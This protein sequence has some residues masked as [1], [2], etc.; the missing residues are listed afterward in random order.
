VG[1]KKKKKNAPAAEP[2]ES[3]TSTN[4]LGVVVAVLLLAGLTAA[5]IF[6]GRQPEA[7]PAA[8]AE[9][10]SEVEQWEQTPPREIAIASSDAA[11]GP[12]DAPVTLV[13]FSDFECPFCRDAAT[14]LRGL[15]ERHGDR[16]RFVFK[17]F[18]LDASCNRH[19]ATAHPLACQ[20]ALVAACAGK[21]G[22]FSTS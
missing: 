10:P 4:R 8:V 17:H 20:A 18:P 5:V 9:G 6:V 2:V 21:Q 16:V 22:R 7:P 12:P 19:F 15:K 11:S 14:V 3:S 13:E 1:K